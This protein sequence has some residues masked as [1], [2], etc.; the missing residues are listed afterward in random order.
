MLWLAVGAWL[1]L[2]A[3]LVYRRDRLVREARSPAAFTDVIGT[4]VLGTRFA[5]QGN[6]AV[7]AALLA[8]AA[9]WWRC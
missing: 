3:R 5:L 8:L 6:H 7:A 2:A 4:A 1:A 9:I